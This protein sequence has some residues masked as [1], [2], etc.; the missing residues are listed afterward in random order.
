M[1]TVSF[2]TACRDERTVPNPTCWDE[3]TVLNPTAAPPVFTRL[4]TKSSLDRIK[5]NVAIDSQKIAVILDRL[6]SESVLKEMTGAMVFPLVE[7]RV[8]NA[9][10]FHQMRKWFAAG[11][12]KQMHMIVHETVVVKDRRLSRWLRAVGDGFFVTTCWD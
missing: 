1:G 9:D 2:V 11:L 12:Y 7:C 10:P 6:A 5:C 4:L 3:G 8:A